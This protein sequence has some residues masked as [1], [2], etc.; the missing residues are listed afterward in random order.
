M[1]PTLS[2]EPPAGK[3]TIILMVWPPGKAPCARAP[4][5]GIRPVASTPSDTLRL[6]SFIC[7]PL[8]TWPSDVQDANWSADTSYSVSIHAPPPR[9]FWTGGQVCLPPDDTYRR[10]GVRW[11]VS[12]RRCSV[13]GRDGPQA[14]A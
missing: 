2:C 5:N 12:H 1:R 14:A 7:C 11:L 6:V 13:F 9:P 4:P 10:Q 8:L 3:P